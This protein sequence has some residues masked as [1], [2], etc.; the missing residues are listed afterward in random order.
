MKKLWHNFKIK[1]QIIVC[2]AHLAELHADRQKGEVDDYLFSFFT[3]YYTFKI[4]KL[5][6][7]LK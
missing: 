3:R 5:R 2:K 1:W 4:I 7:Q 6:K